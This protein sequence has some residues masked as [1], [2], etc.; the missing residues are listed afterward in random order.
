MTAP[1]ATGDQQ[2]AGRTFVAVSKRM[3]YF[4]ALAAACFAK[5]E[6][7]QALGYPLYNRASRVLK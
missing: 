5:L 6:S 7:A 1:S 4:S 3:E 2:V